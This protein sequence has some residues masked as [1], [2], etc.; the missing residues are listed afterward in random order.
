MVDSSVGAA[1]IFSNSAIDL[2]GVCYLNDKMNVPVKQE[3]GDY[4]EPDLVSNREQ[5]L[6]YS[7]VGR[8]NLM[9]RYSVL[10]SSQNF[11]TLS[12]LS[13]EKQRFTLSC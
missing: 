11:L 6:A 13:G 9:L 8:R 2:N 4:M 3:P 7:R 10:S 5:Y 12:V 1:A